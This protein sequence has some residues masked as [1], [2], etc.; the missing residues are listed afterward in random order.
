VTRQKLGLIL[1][2]VFELAFQRVS[3]RLGP[4]KELAQIGATIGREFSHALLAAVARKPETELASAVDRQNPLRNGSLASD[5]R[6]DRVDAE[7]A[8]NDA[9][10]I[11]RAA[12]LIY[13][14]VH[15]AFPLIFSGR[16]ET[17]HKLLDHVI[18]LAQERS[19]DYLKLLATMFSGCLFAVTGSAPESVRLIT[20]AITAVRLKGGSTLWV[21]LYLSS[22]AI[23]YAELGQVDDA[24]H[25]IGE[26]LRTLEAT[27]EKWCE[28]EVNRIAGEI[29]LVSPE[30][31]ATKAEAHFVRALAVARQQQAKSWELRAAMSLARLWRDQGKPQQARELL[32]PVYGWFT[33]GFD[34]LDLK[35]AKTLLDELHA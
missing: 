13:T 30:R 34:T 1:G 4:A 28:A 11:G 31:D 17:A 33:E 29:A 6:L 12:D 20:A 32:A 7:R 18:V 10:E 22:L 15:I 27:G 35:D 9:R 23:A 26:A 8:L 25:S 21:P 5:A 19:A 2:Y 24:W 3:D 16:Y 14:A